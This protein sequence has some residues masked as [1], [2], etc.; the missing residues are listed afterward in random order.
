M[1]NKAPEIKESALHNGG[2]RTVIRSFF[3]AGA[4]VQP[5][6]HTEFEE[7]F[8]V[9]EGE[10]L[11]QLDDKVEVL[12]KGQAIKIPKRTI[13]SF[14]MLSA[15]VLEISLM[16]GSPSFEQAIAIIRGTQADDLFQP[17]V[18]DDMNLVLM[19]VTA[20][21]TN[22]MY[23]GETGQLLLDFY[24]KTGE[25]ISEVKTQWMEKYCQITPSGKEKHDEVAGE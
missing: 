19:A 5:H 17:G 25:M 20:E 24:N 9:V 23:I 16:P 18:L 21:L 7:T 1:K 6:Y 3:H 14:S 11:V 13:H 8:H 4:A 12:F 22:S 15:G 2:N 10:M